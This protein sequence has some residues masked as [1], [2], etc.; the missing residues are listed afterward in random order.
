[1]PS[2][3]G[4]SGLGSITPRYMAR[5]FSSTTWPGCRSGS[6]LFPINKLIHSQREEC[7]YEPLQEFDVVL[8][9]KFHQLL[10]VC[11]TRLEKIH[12]KVQAIAN[13]KLFGQCEPPWLHRVAFAKV[14]CFNS[15]VVVK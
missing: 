5:F 13:H 1:M 3:M 6:I 14:M 7:R 15:G 9:M 4:Q 12:G 10:H 8:R 11:V 2:K